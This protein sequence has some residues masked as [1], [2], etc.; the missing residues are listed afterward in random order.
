M[1]RMMPAPANPPRLGASPLAHGRA[2]RARTQAAVPHRAAFP[3]LTIPRRHSIPAAR[4]VTDLSF[5]R[6]SIPAEAT[7]PRAAG[8][9]ADQN[10]PRQHAAP[11]RRR[12]HNPP[13]TLCKAFAPAAECGDG[14]SSGVSPRW[15][16]PSARASAG[17][18]YQII[19][20][21]KIIY[22][23]SRAFWFRV[24]QQGAHLHINA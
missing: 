8:T 4:A 6:I 14:A 16:P 2:T 18:A 12:R 9:A 10:R 21:S 13:H 7:R 23:L 24:I 3:T 22:M 19:T 11:P 20:W 1:K 17:A 5:P 15:P